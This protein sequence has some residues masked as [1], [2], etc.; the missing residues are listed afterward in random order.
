MSMA[1]GMGGGFGTAF[2]RQRRL[3]GGVFRRRFQVAARAQHVP[4]MN[5]A[6]NSLKIVLVLVLILVLSSAFFNVSESRKAND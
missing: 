4:L 3:D 6:V 2:F 1:T 5:Q